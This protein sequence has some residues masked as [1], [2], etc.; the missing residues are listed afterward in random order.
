QRFSGDCSVWRGLHEVTA[1]PEEEL[2]FA[3]THGTDG[4]DRIPAVLTMRIEP[5]LALDGI[6]EMLRHSFPDTHR[7]IALHI[8]M[9]THRHH[10]GASLSDVS[11]RQRKIDDLLDGCHSVAVLCQ[12]H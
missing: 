5:E 3:I 11:L 10:T 1:E 4:I 2:P 7:A 6:E 8:G 9:S 12:S